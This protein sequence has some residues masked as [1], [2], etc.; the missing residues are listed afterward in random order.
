MHNANK[1]FAAVTLFALALSTTRAAKPLTADQFLDPT[2]VVEVKI[3]L[4]ADDWEELR[5]Q[6]RDMVTAISDTD[7]KPFTYFR[8]DVTVDGVEIKSVGI[9]KKGFIGSLDDERPSLKIKFAEYVDQSPVDGLDRLTLNNNK[10]DTS[11]LSQFLSY[12]I[13]RDAGVHA[14]RSSFARVTVNDEYLGIYSHIESVKKDF[15]ARSFGHDVSTP[16]NLYEGT[17]ADLYIQSVDKM[18][19]KTNKK[20]KNRPHLTALAQL[21]S[22]DDDLDLDKLE[23]TID[24]DNF[25]R[26]W[27]AEG[28][29]KHRDGYNAC[30]LYTSPSPR[31]LSTS[32]MPSSA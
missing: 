21:V 11:Q 26:F 23:K 19:A 2:R 29:V 27:A 8:G 18:E 14:C 5:N 4:P 3:T 13:F 10:Q 32:R 9:R 31:D 22:S 16:G 6:S 28:L 1:L 25:L 20:D 17:L 7:A 30:L 12:R 24:I 15:L